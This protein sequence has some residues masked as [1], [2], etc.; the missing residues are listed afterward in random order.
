MLLGRRMVGGGGLGSGKVR[1]KKHTTMPMETWYGCCSTRMVT[2]DSRPRNAT[3]G[4]RISR[5]EDR[6]GDGVW[7]RQ[8]SW[9]KDGSAILVEDRGKGAKQTT[10]FDARGTMVK[11]EKDKDRDGHPE[12][13]WYYERGVLQK[14][15]KTRGTWFYKDGQMA[16]AEIDTD[17]D[18]RIDRKEYYR[19]GR[20]DPCRGNECFRQGSM[21]MDL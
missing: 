8:F 9:Q 18:G 4:R 2:K 3:T 20:L 6:D 7:E 19:Q 16:H 21:R 5:R 1:V 11:V 15:V 14:V 12:T 13:T 10:W 17:H